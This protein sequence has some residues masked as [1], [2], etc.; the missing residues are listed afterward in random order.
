M[1]KAPIPFGALSPQLGQDEAA[2]R[3]AFERVLGRGWFLA[4]PEVE[5][6]ESE[7]AEWLGLPFSVSY[8]FV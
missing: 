2:L 1:I 3:A 6:F 7:F 4:G 8:N 5:A